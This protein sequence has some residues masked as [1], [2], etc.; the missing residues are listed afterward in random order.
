VRDDLVVHRAVLTDDELNAAIAISQT[1]PGP[2]G[3][4]VVIVGYFVDGLSGALVGMA[5][6]AT[7]ALLALPLITIVRRGRADLVRG[8]SSG[9]VLASGVL[10]VLAALRLAPTAI[11]SPGLML[12][13]G[14]AFV[15]L[16]TEKTSPL[17]AVAI[18]AAGALL[19][20]SIRHL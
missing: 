4:Y 2:L 19:V 14:A 6:L 5:A 11:S 20:G 16:A 3:L 10:M 15:L 1:S 7:P 17:V 9:I 12:L 18:A 8:A 13:A